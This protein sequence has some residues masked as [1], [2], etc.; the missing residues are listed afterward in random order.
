MN[1]PSSGNIIRR[2]REFRHFGMFRARAFSLVE[3]IVVMVTIG[4]LAAIAIPRF[5]HAAETVR[6]RAAADELVRFAQVAEMYFAEHQRWPDDTKENEVP[7]A[8]DDYLDGREFTSTPIGGNYDWENWDQAN[9]A[10]GGI[11][12]SIRRPDR[13]ADAQRV[14]AILDDGN[15]DTGSVWK[16]GTALIYTIER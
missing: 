16:S 7:T 11:H 15:L 3:L 12:M 14:D 4:V 8:F 1:P 9:Y 6:V 13:W 2:P 10:P 5:S